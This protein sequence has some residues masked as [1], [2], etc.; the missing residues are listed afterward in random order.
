MGLLCRDCR[1]N[2]THGFGRLLARGRKLARD[3]AVQAVEIK[4]D[5]RR[6]VEREQL[7][8]D[9]AADHR[10]TQRLAELGACAAA[11]RDR[12]RAENRGESWSS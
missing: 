2:R 5:D 10:D 6:D 9:Q 8:E 11:E 12:Q 7:R 3:L 4:V 1:R